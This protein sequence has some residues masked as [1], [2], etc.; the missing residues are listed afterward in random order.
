MDRIFFK[1]IIWV[2]PKE[3][4]VKFETFFVRVEG[5]FKCLDSKSLKVFRRREI[6]L[7]VLKTLKE[8]PEKGMRFSL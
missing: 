1:E 3:A 6:G 7:K 8:R 5:H 2:W 4:R